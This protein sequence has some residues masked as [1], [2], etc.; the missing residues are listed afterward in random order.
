[1][2]KTWE[3]ERSHKLD[4]KTHM[5][6]DQERFRIGA[7]GGEQFDNVKANEIGNYNVLLQG[8]D[9]EL[10][11]TDQSWEG[12]HEA[13]KGAFQTFPWEVIE[14]FSGPPVVAFTWRHWGHFTG[15]YKNNQGKGELLELF[16]FGTAE[17]NDKLQLC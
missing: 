6:V 9:K 14:V 7:N 17:V 5:T 2:G 1:M 10:Y 3:M 15:S 16:G 13:F 8:C 11:D 12:S 4:P